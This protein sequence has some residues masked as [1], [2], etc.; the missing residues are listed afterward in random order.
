[1]LRK[2]SFLV[3]FLLGLAP[4]FGGPPLPGAGLSLTAGM[5]FQ[6]RPE[7]WGSRFILGYEKSF[8]EWTGFA[9]LS[10][11]H[12]WPPILSKISPLETEFGLAF[13]AALPSAF[14]GG[15]QL[16]V[17]AA[18]YT[19]TR[20]G[21][22]IRSEED[23]DFGDEEYA[24]K[25]FLEPGLPMELRMHGGWFEMRPFFILAEPSRFGLDLGMRIPP[26]PFRAAASREQEGGLGLRIDFL[27]LA[28]MQDSPCE[29]SG[30]ASSQA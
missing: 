16:A 5:Q 19:G 21:R 2:P 17:G 24:E 6:S 8:S 15:I 22:L 30:C 14:P 18:L 4:S 12:E 9:N 20:R 1:M 27:S 10:A 7:A 26:K 23:S 3:A 28:N 13:M 11:Y 29:D 25:V